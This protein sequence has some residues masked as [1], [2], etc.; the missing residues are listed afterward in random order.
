MRGLDSKRD[1]QIP[2]SPRT[3]GVRSYSFGHHPVCK[4]QTSLKSSSLDNDRLDDAS[5]KKDDILD[6]PIII[7]GEYVFLET[8]FVSANCVS[9]K[10]VKANINTNHMWSLRKGS[11]Q[12]SSQLW[13]SSLKRISVYVIKYPV[14]SQSQRVYLRHSDWKADVVSDIRKSLFTKHTYKHKLMIHPK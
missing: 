9:L 1:L 11:R 13:T 3:G 14:L 12:I 2:W 5:L 7:V 4:N 8:I 6:C 10:P